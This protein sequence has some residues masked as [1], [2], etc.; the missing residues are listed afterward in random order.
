MKYRRKSV[1]GS[2]DLLWEKPPGKILEGEKLLDQRWLL[3]LL[4]AEGI[5]EP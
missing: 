1:D 2:E 3:P 5:P 4:G